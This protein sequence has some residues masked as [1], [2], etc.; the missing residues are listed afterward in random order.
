MAV[1]GVMWLPAFDWPEAWY[2]FWEVVVKVLIFATLLT[3]IGSGL[4]YVLRV[5]RILSEVDR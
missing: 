4:S 1:G 5:R 3:T 2:S